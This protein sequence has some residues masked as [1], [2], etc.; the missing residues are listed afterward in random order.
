M[1]GKRPNVIFSNPNVVVGSIVEKTVFG[2]GKWEVRYGPRNQPTQKCM[3]I[4]EATSGGTNEG[5]Y[6]VVWS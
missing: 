4:S 3:D 2:G 1:S 5:G 6:K